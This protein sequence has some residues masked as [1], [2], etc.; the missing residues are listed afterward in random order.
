ML[1]RAGSFSGWFRWLGLFAFW[2]YAGWTDLECG[3][4]GIW[5]G[6]FRFGGGAETHGIVTGNDGLGGSDSGHNRD[7]LLDGAGIFLGWQDHLRDARRGSG[8]SVR[9]AVHSA[10]WRE[11]VGSDGEW[12]NCPRRR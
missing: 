8:L 7:G 2:D 6:G 5:S 10:E 3:I 4:A 12:Y 11:D 1:L 9:L